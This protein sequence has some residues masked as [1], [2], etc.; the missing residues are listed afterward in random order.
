VVEDRCPTG[1]TLPVGASGG[2]GGALQVGV[3]IVEGEGLQ[4]DHRGR[5]EHVPALDDVGI[6]PGAAGQQDRG[7]GVEFGVQPPHRVRLQ[8]CRDLVKAVQDRQHP[9]GGQQLTAPGGPGIGCGQRGRHPFLQTLPVRLPVRHGEH[10]GDGVLRPA[11]LQQIQGEAQCQHTLAASRLAQHHQPPGRHLGKD[12]GDLLEPDTQVFWAVDVLPVIGKPR[13]SWRPANLQRG[14]VLQSPQPPLRLPLFLDHFG[15]LPCEPV[16]PL[17][18]RRPALLHGSFA[19]QTYS[20][21]RHG[22]PEPEHRRQRAGVAKIPILDRNSKDHARDERRCCPDAM[23]PVP[24]HA[25]PRPLNSPARRIRSAT[26][27]GNGKDHASGDELRPAPP[28][29]TTADHQQRS[30]ATALDQCEAG[31][32]AL[33]GRAWLHSR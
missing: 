32:V 18:P 25:A 29:R 20:Q 17:L 4:F 16:D 26:T 22:Q 5:G 6:H 11:V 21:A 9:A 13:V 10:H 30:I 19:Q 23:P 33:V 14:G 3:G 12:L 24:P 2:A 28:A 1:R 15:Q 27:P 8:G 7:I 31:I